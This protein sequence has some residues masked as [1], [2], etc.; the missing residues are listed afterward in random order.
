[1]AAEVHWLDQAKR[2]LREILDHIALDS[3]YAAERY[4]AE[5][6]T[7]CDRLKLFPLSGRRYD[8][9]FRVLVFRNHLIFHSHDAESGVVS[10]VT[11]LDGRRDLARLLES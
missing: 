5:L 10:I 9:N 1:M 3:P 2:D 8:D 7:A 11:V 4:V 6:Q